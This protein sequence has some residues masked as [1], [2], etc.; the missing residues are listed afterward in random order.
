[1]SVAPKR[2]FFIFVHLSFC[3]RGY[4]VLVGYF[5]NHPLYTSPSKLTFKLS[6]LSMVEM[7]HFIC[8][9]F[10]ASEKNLMFSLIFEMQ[11]LNYAVELQIDNKG[12]IKETRLS[13]LVIQHFICSQFYAREKKPNFL[14]HF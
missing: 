7:S 3:Y 1:M 14:T 10:Y 13:S 11:R 8:S 12:R 6:D 9:Q 4:G 5:V 2:L